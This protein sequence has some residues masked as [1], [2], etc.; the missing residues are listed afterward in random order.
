MFP[1]QTKS[2]LTDTS[3]VVRCLNRSKAAGA[4][5]PRAPESREAILDCRFHLGMAES[6]S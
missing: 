3:S 4:G 2:N 5:E 6:R 1:V